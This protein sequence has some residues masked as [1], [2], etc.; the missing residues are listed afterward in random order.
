M[1]SKFVYLWPQNCK[2]LQFSSFLKK[3]FF[4]NLWYFEVKDIRTLRSNFNIPLP[5]STQDWSLVKH[6]WSASRCDFSLLR[7]THPGFGFFDITF[8]H[9]FGSKIFKI[10]FFPLNITEDSWNEFL[11]LV[12]VLWKYL[13]QKIQIAIPQLIYLSLFYPCSQN[14]HKN[15]V[16]SIGSLIFWIWIAKTLYYIILKFHYDIGSIMPCIFF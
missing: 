3:Q 14:F 5:T 11:G 10:E 15:G 16:P 12:D 7:K 8:M 1:I 2:I 6:I 13:Q 4:D 9:I